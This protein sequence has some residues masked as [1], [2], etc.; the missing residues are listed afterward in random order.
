MYFNVL[1]LEI[2]K[3]IL[4]QMGKSEDL[5]EFV[6]DRKGHDLR[7]AINSDKVEKE[8]GWKRSYTFDKGM[9]ETIDWYLNN[10]KW[11][12]DILSGEYKKAYKK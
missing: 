11:I 1:N 2:I 4:K 9:Q 7:Y 5:I 12:D 3:T 6:A 8:L 10:T